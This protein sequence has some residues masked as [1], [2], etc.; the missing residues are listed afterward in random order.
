MHKGKTKFMTNYETD[1]IITVEG[2]NIEKVEEYKYLGQNIKMKD[3]TYE[4]VMKRI[5]SGWSCFGRHKDILCDKRIPMIWRKK[6]FNQCVLST[7]TYGAETWTTTK[8]LE[9]KLQTAQR[10]ME[11]KMLQI[12]IRDKVRCSEIRKKTGVKDIIEKIKEAKWRWAGHVARLNDNR[13]TR[14]ILEWQPRTGKRKRGRQKKRW[15]DDITSY[16]G[17]TWTRQARERQLWKDHEEGYIRQ[18]MDTA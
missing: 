10:A 3:C 18:W 7:M 1:S 2:H 11:R 14:R 8:Y 4:E 15:R 13:W 6:V 17:T 12:S 9:N 5:K 16:L